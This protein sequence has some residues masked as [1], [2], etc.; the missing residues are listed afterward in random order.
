MVSNDYTWWWCDDERWKVKKG[1]E[2]LKNKNK[3]K[4]H[5]VH[6]NLCMITTSVPI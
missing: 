6:D 5:V 3:K 2:T 4:K 1:L